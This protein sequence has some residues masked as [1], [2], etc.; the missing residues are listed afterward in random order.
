[1]FSNRSRSALTTTVLATAASGFL[2]SCGDQY[3]ERTVEDAAPVYCTNEAGEVVDD[4]YCDTGYNGGGGGLFFLYMGGGSHRVG[5]RVAPGGVKVNA[6]DTAARAKA[7][8]PGTGKV[9][10]GTRVSGGIGSGVGGKAG[11]ARG[12]GGS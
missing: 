1:M 3:E 11:T 10:N 5:D 2:T 8:L 7:G 4:D 6:K 12:G 9:G